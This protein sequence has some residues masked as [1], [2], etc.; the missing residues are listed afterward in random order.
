MDTKNTKNKL[1][2][3]LILMIAIGGTAQAQGIVDTIF[4]PFTIILVVVVIVAIL[5]LLSGIVY[6]SRYE[7]GI[8]TKKMFG[9]KMPQGQI[10]ARNGEIGIQAD[11]LMPGLYFFNPITWRIEK[12][13]V[14]VVTET[15]IGVVESVD[16]E[17]IPTG[18]L[19]G[20]AVECN[21]YQD[22]RA[23]L[24]NKGKKGP[25]IA[26][27]RPGTYRVNTRAFIIRKEKVTKIGEEKLGVAIAM[28]GKPLLSGLIIAPKPLDESHRFY[29]DGQAFINSGGSRGPQ[30][31]T[32]QPGEYYINPLLF[33][34][35]VF[36]VAEVP[37]GYV[38]VIRSNV[39]EEL[40]KSSGLP[41]DVEKEPGFRQEVH[42]KDEVV[43]TTDKN[44]RGIWEKPVAPGKYNLNPLAYTAYLV[45]T[46]AVTI[47]WAAGPELRTEHQG[48]V[49]G[50]MTLG[51]TKG[52]SPKSEE[53]SGEKASEFFKF[54]QLT[55]TSKDGF[56][57]EADVRIIIRIRPQHASF[58]IARFGSVPNLIEQIVHPLIDSS[59]RNKAG[60]KKAIDF[61][62]SRT[63]LQK[64]AIERA[65]E[66]FEKYYVEAQ[67]LLI[68]YIKVDPTLLKT[69]TDK[70]IALQQQEQFKE[71]AN[72]QEENIAVQE[73]TARAAKQKDVIDAKLSKDIEAD[74]AD[75]ARRKAE[76]VRDSTKYEADGE[77]YKNRETGKGMAD[78]YK[79]Q[80]EVIGPDK[81][82]LIKVIEQVSAGKIKIVP[83]FLIQGGSGEQSGNLFN[84][85][86][87]NM[88]KDQTEKK[89]EEKKE[90]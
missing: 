33:E 28:D 79:A 89:K 90:D 7:V 11:T 51:S 48:A 40:T 73:K 23:F 10:I 31:D 53:V 59:F 67:N 49:P 70:E 16:G 5:F 43:L 61:I 87:A 76:G 60:E 26:I 78:A 84:A 82:A 24:D 34:V 19:L 46:S 35:K 20:D 83:D 55:L 25:Q 27:L 32:L 1:L 42:E 21:N 4:N 80:A 86:M 37:P 71:Q 13:R 44:Q 38:A 58:I 9:A 75:A 81:L 69:Q 50:G 56:I 57:L 62:Q 47:D 45:P 68:S 65:R 52:R 39:G 64:E 77:A 74:R 30:L 15:E 17:P 22:T 12:E 85:W 3:A 18:R 36:D 8:K 88:V 41:S 14:T 72:A 29:Q 63:A 6:I 66:E 2:V 54:S